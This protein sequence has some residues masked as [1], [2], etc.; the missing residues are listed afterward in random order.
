MKIHQH[1]TRIFNKTCNFEV[2]IG[3]LPL[4]LIVP[5]NESLLQECHENPSTW[6][7]DIL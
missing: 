7:Q 2:G 3:L 5:S 6:S 1:G 4:I